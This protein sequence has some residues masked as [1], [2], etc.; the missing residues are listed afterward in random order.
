MSDL[1]TGFNAIPS[2]PPPDNKNPVDTPGA[3]SLNCKH[4]RIDA[5]VAQQDRASVS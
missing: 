2:R 4:L 3:K 5:P 1:R